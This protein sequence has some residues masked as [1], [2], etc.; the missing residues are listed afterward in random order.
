ME[1]LFPN[2]KNNEIKICQVKYY[3]F[4]K[5]L[6]L[7]LTIFLISYLSGILHE[8]G[9][10]II[11]TI[12]LRNPTMSFFGI[13]QMWEP[14]LYSENWVKITI[15]GHGDGW[16]RLSSLPG[17]AMEWVL[18]LLAGQ[19]TQPILI[20]VG[21]HLWRKMEKQIYKELGIIIMFMN[22]IIFLNIIIN[23]FSGFGDL[24]FINYFTG[25]PLE[26]LVAFFAGF[27]FIGFLFTLIKIK[28]LIKSKKVGIYFFIAFIISKILM[29]IIGIA[30]QFIIEQ[31]NLENPLFQPILGWSIPAL[32]T[33]IGFA[34]ILMFL[35]IKKHSRL[36]S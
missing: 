26:I 8:L 35:L 4:K 1:D 7:T 31:I 16:L 22:S 24:H 28:T 27:E 17:S 10:Q 3:N 20:F 23:Y 15:L 6:L 11:L 32:I 21:W 30:H 34:F 12:T 19:L 29:K 14:P 5:F 13:V 25:F 33:N 2:G 9:H 36:F 18:M